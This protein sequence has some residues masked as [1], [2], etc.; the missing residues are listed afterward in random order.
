MYFI[1]KSDKKTYQTEKITFK[2]P[3]EHVLSS[4]AN[5]AEVQIHHREVDDPDNKLIISVFLDED[6]EESVEDNKFLDDILPEGW[7]MNPQ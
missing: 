2:F 4:G 7:N 1:N 3:A 6:T 5:G